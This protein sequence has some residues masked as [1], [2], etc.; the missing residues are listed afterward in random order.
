M[1]IWNEKISG[2]QLAMGREEL[3]SLL[4]CKNGPFLMEKENFSGS[5]ATH[6]ESRSKHIWKMHKEII[7]KEQ[8]NQR[9]FPVLRVGESNSCRGCELLWINDC[10]VLSVPPPFEQECPLESLCL[11]IIRCIECEGRGVGGTPLAGLFS[12]QVSVK[13]DWKTTPEEFHPHRPNLYGRLLEDG[14]NKKCPPNWEGI[15]SYFPQI[16][17]WMIKCLNPCVLKTKFL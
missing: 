6:P 2:P 17:L 7:P 11:C 14:G 9:T 1:T 13:L 15:L 8:N 12:S 5:K 3:K 4:S 16:K 10:Y